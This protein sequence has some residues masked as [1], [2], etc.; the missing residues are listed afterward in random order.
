ME[1]FLR[2]MSIKVL[3]LKA[4]IRE[5]DRRAIIAAFNDPNNDAQIFLTSYRTT[6]LGINLQ[7]ACN[8]VREENLW[9]AKIE[10]VHSAGKLR[11]QREE[12]I[13]FTGFRGL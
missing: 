3:S 9:I 4:D 13:I 5:G 6:S 11:V 8:N 10:Q 2:I 7:Y 1:G 12:I